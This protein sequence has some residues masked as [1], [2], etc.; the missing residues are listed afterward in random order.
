M[1]IYSIKEIVDATNNF[2]KPE[3][4]TNKK[5]NSLKKNKPLILIDETPKNFK[6]QKKISKTDLNNGID[7]KTHKNPT[8]NNNLI[9]ELYL[10]FNKK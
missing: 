7:E 3:A 9:N 2:L 5:T 6:N 4:N 10:K 8:D 1:I